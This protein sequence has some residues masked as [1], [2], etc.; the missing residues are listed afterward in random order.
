MVQYNEI[1]GKAVCL[2]P[3]KLHVCHIA[4]IAGG[5]KELINDK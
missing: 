5:S 3:I 4:Y 2:H 1:A